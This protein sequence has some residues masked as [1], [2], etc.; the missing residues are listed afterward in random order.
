VVLAGKKWRD[1]MCQKWAEGKEL[2]DSPESYSTRGGEVLVWTPGSRPWE[3]KGKD[4]LD[5]RG[6]EFR[7]PNPA[8]PSRTWE[9]PRRG[10]RQYPTSSALRG[11]ETE[12]ALELWNERRDQSQGE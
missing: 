8:T 1:R 12:P 4:S 6:E 3:K 9:A 5:L 10:D 11:M 2:Q 7:L